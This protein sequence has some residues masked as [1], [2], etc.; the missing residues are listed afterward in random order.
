MQNVDG[1]DHLDANIAGSLKNLSFKGDHA[2]HLAVNERSRGDMN[3]PG[4]ATGASVGMG[5][6]GTS[7]ARSKTSW[8]TPAP[9]LPL[10]T[11][12]VCNLHEFQLRLPRSC[13]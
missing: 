12:F 13:T 7:P 5:A 10:K 4:M 1:F 8:T 3:C 2:Y 9:R 6:C 11:H